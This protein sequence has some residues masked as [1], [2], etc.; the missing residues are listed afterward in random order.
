MLQACG[1]HDARRHSVDDKEAT[2]TL[3]VGDGEFT[4][5][6][7]EVYEFDVSGLK[8]V[9]S[10]L[11]YRMKDPKGKKSSPLDEINLQKWPSEFN[12]ELLELLWVLE[13]T[14]AEYPAQAKLLAKIVKGKCFMADEL[15]AVPD[16]MRKPPARKKQKSLFDSV[17]NQE[18]E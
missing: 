8:V 15:P 2:K 14:L 1:P 10:W 5:V 9:Q 11:A 13:E 18:D 12:T 17:E 6:A 3:H 4:P 7:P 16:H